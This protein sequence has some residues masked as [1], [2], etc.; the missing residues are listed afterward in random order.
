VSEAG[1]ADPRT[2][3][4]VRG[5]LAAALSLEALVVLLVPPTIAQFGSGLVGWK[6]A[7]VLALAG[8]LVLAA[9]LL[10]RPAGVPLG[11]ALQVAL[12]GCGFLTAAMFVLGVVFAGIWV[13]LLRLRRN[14]LGT[15]PP[16]P[17]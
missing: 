5:T 8:L 10:R 6:L 13:F 14:L 3:R 17:G 16:A 12:I 1:G 2:E 9:A 15:R 4:A 11:T 7:L